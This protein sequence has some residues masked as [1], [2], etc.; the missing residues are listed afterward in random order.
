MDIVFTVHIILLNIFIVSFSLSSSSYLYNKLYD[1]VKGKQKPGYA[2]FWAIVLLSVVWN[3][4]PS[5]LVL[6]RF[7]YKVYSSLAIVIPL[8]LFVAMLFKKNSKFPIPGPWYNVK[9]SSRCVENSH[10]LSRE[11]LWCSRCVASHIV[12]VLSIWSLLITFTFF[13]HYLTSIIVSLYLDPLNSL[14]KVLFIKAI[15]VSFIIN[16]ALLFV[17]DSFS[18]KPKEVAA[19]FLSV[20]SILSALPVLAVFLV[21][22]GGIVFNEG[23]P[24]DNAWKPIFTL[25]PSFLLLFASWYSHGK[26]FPKGR[27][28]K[29]PVTEI[30]DDLEGGT[31]AS[32]AAASN[33]AHTQIPMNEAT[34]LLPHPRSDDQT[35]SVHSRAP[36]GTDSSNLGDNKAVDV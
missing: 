14:V 16:V 6:S 21:M 20:L 32:P 7:D 25:V 10:S 5:W 9:H 13:V 1:N 18:S 30:V 24:Q 23:S 19:S 35:T 22:I 34:P 28:D 36:F 17:L 3:V 31:T 15:L 4:G 11:V 29:D 12:Q 8:Q 26:L 27:K 33:S 2:L